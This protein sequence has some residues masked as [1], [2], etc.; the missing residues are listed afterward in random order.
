MHSVYTPPLVSG[1]VR[2]VMPCSVMY[3]EYAGQGSVGAHSYNKSR[4]NIS[5]SYTTSQNTHA[6][7]NTAEKRNDLMYTLA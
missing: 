1:S 2:H 3:R 4:L 6:A 7:V 5:Q